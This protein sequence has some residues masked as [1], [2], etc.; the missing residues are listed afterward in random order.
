MSQVNITVIPPLTHSELTAQS[1]RGEFADRFWAKVTIR[2]PQRCWLWAGAASGTGYKYGQVAWRSRYRTPQRAHRVAWELFHGQP[3]PAGNVIAHHCDIPLCCNPSHLFLTTQHGNLADARQKG[4]LVCGRHLI[5]VSDAG[6]ADI[7][8]NY[9]P[10]Y[11]G[12]HLAAKYG[13][14][15]ISL[16]R[17]VNGTQRVSRPIF[18]RVPSVHLEIRGEVA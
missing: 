4:R 10:R 8:A 3:V 5:K 2:G 9:R 17:I 18:E 12:K 6:I 1:L 16:L 13:I 15:L 7:R 14:T 11:N